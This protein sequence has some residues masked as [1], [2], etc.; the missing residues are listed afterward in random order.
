MA[1]VQSLFGFTLEGEPISLYTI[2]NAS[3]ASLCVTTMGAAIQSLRVPDREGKLTDII[4]GFDQGEDYCT[5][6]PHFGAMI[7][8]C[9]NRI[10]GAEFTLGGTTYP[11]TP[12]SGKNH[13]HGGDRGFDRKN[14]DARILD[15][16][17]LELTTLCPH[18]EDGYPGNLQVT[19]RYRWDDENRLTLSWEGL[20]DRDTIFNPTSHCYFNLNGQ[21]SGDVRSHRV[22]LN[23]AHRL[24]L[25]GEFLPT[26]KLLEVAGTE[27]DLT[28]MRTL[29][30]DG[31]QAAPKSGCY[32]LDGEKAASVYSNETGIRM[33]VTTSLPFLVFYTGYA[34]KDTAGKQGAQYGPYCGLCIETSYPV[35]AIHHPEFPQ[36]TL[37]SGQRRISHT[38]YHFT[39]R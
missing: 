2:T 27:H 11:L 12:N 3:G 32:L 31:V 37:K 8:P 9:C 23:A 22:Q 6:K 34:V 18:G 38:C 20:S 36:F 17:T 24:E 15:S 19:L 4:P 25:D 35:D 1:I 33:D 7:G 30:P 39:G 16:E 13:I 21:G 10:R 5:N 28:A 29:S 26:G 14:W